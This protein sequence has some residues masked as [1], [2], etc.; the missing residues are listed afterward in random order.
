MEEAA[1]E[2]TYMAVQARIEAMKVTPAG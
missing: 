1:D 2:G